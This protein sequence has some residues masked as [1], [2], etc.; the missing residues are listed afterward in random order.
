MLVVQGG[1][2]WVCCPND[3]FFAGVLDWVQVSFMHVV[4]MH[5]LF[6]CISRIEANVKTVLRVFAEQ[7]K[8]H[9][10]GGGIEFGLHV[11]DVRNEV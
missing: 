8:V 9:D 11:K 1:D 5:V 4:F 2:F 6:E 3:F 7:R 10:T